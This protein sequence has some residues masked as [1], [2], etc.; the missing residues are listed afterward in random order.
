MK[1]LQ[2]L[3]ALSPLTLLDSNLRETHGPHSS[4]APALN[5]PN[6]AM[7]LS[8]LLGTW[9]NLPEH[10]TPN[11]QYLV[12]FSSAFHSCVPTS[13]AFLSTALGIFSI[14]S[15]LFAQMPQIYKNYQLQ[16][17]SGLSI[18]FLGEWLLGDLANLLGA[19]LTRQAGWQV[20]VAGYY[21]FVD[22]GLVSQYFWY[23]HLKSSR[24]GR[25][26]GYGSETHGP[27]GGSGEVLV[28][29]SPSVESST[30]SAHTEDRKPDTKALDTPA[31]PQGIQ[32]PPRDI[33]SSFSKEKDTMGSFNRTIKRQGTPSFGPSPRALLLISMLCVV[34]TNASP[35][36]AQIKDESSTVS[37]PELAGRIFS[38]CSTVL[39]L[40]SRLPQIYKNALRRSTAGLSP[41][42]FIAAFFG[43]LFYSASLLTNPLAW[44]SYR[45]YGLHGWVGPEGSDRATWVALAAPFWLGAAGVLALDATIGIQFLIFGEGGLEK[46][47][48]TQ[49]REGRS[50]WRR[51]SGWM[52]G[53]VPSPSPPASEDVDEGEG[54]RLLGQRESRGSSY[55]AA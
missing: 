11:S 28:G 40:G 35:L 8:S 5:T 37:S 25:L 17:A 27:D 51:V 24:K 1:F 33:S 31:K 7:S 26:L 23:T 20:V 16:S 10:C 22:I 12:N 41:T 44:E 47:V 30:E 48:L 52:R 13:P 55:G 38:W 21:V 15:W 50:R 6:A 34:L 14:I 46:S 45:P 53:W 39:Y 18:Y 49:D 3:L 43:N 36:H 29:V 4:V 54:R 32:G 2:G 42:L 9:A 19:I